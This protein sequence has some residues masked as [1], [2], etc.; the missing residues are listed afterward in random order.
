MAAQSRC[1]KHLGNIRTIHRHPI[2]QLPHIRLDS[3]ARRSGTAHLVDKTATEWGAHFI[4]YPMRVTGNGYEQGF[5][6]IVADTCLADLGLDAKN[7]IKFVPSTFHP[8]SCV[9][10]HQ[11]PRS[12]PFRH[13]F[14]RR[15]CTRISRVRRTQ[16]VRRVIQSCLR[17]VAIPRLLILHTSPFE[18]TLFI[19]IACFFPENN[20]KIILQNRLCLRLRKIGG[21]DIH[22]LHKTY[23]DQGRSLLLSTWTSL[24][25][26]WLYI[27]DTRFL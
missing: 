19:F 18:I 21:F 20:F 8:I 12:S 23:Q 22:G 17:H 15:I 2:E 14:C 5:L 6:I 16:K 7:Q 25:V 13:L 27:S 3:E 10:A 1:H 24:P 4:L 9:R 11:R 26:M